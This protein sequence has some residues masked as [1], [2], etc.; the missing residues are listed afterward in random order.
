MELASEFKDL[1]E[2]ED[3]V[4]YK[5][6]L[7]FL[8]KD[9][10]DLEFKYINRG[11]NGKVF[12]FRNKINPDRVYALKIGALKMEL[13]FAKLKITEKNLVNFLDFSQNVVV[14]ELCNK[15]L[16]HLI[17]EDRPFDINI[18]IAQLLNGL[19]K[20]HNYGFAHNDFKPKNIFCKG[21]ESDFELLIG[22]FANL[23]QYNLKSPNPCTFLYEPPEKLF[24]SFSRDSRKYDIWALGMVILESFFKKQFT[25][26]YI[27]ALETTENDLQKSKEM[28]IKSFPEMIEIFPNENF[29]D[30]LKG[31]LEQ[32]HNERYDINECI[33]KFVNYIQDSKEVSEEY[34]Q[35]VLNNLFVDNYKNQTFI[36]KIQKSRQ[37]YQEL[38]K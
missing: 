21:N 9:T 26:V 5:N 6:S 1:S 23:S 37:Q 12:G 18:M 32:N 38:Y 11:A 24:S 25:N 36:K 15:D 14:M 30:L 35:K 10:T 4:N 20:I 29:K 28:F 22:D 16:S 17:Y 19:S 27:N 33:K 3:L 2:F 8:F 13:E 34:K 31:M 7:D